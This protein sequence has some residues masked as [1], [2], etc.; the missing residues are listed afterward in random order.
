MIN[1]YRVTRRYPYNSVNC[2][3]KYDVSARQ[4]YYVRAKNKQLAVAN[5]VRGNSLLCD[6]DFVCGFDVQLFKRNIQTHETG[7]K[8]R[9]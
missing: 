6:M 9:K 2:V 8:S 7:C 4:G 3:G 1:E 5:F